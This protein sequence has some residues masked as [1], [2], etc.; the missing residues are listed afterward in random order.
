MN[1]TKPDLKQIKS[2]I[3]KTGSQPRQRVEYQVPVKVEPVDTSTLRPQQIVPHKLNTLVTWLVF[4]LTL[5]VYM[6]TQARS[7][8]FWD[9]GEYATCISILG[10]PH[11]PGNPFYILFGRALVTLFGG[12][13]SHAWLAAFISA[14]TSAF[15]VMFTYLLTVQLASMF[16]IK[17]WEAIFAG[18]MAATLTA[19]SFTFW[20]NAVEAEVYSGLVFFVNMIIWL[21]LYWVQ[22]ARDF[23]NQNILLLILYLFF[24][25]F[26]VHQ[27]A[28]QIAP[29]ILFIA[30]YPLLIQGGK[31]ETFWYKFFGYGAALIMAYLLFG[32]IGKSFRVDALDQIGLALMIV[33]IMIVELHKII[34]PRVWFIGTALVVI[35][36]SAHVMLP[37]RAADRPFINLA[38]PSTPKM[39]DDYI[40]RRQYKPVEQTSMFQRKGN[41]ITHQLGYHFLRYFS[42]Q[43]FKTDAVKRIINMPEKVI[44]VFGGLIVAFLGLFGAVFHFRKNKHSFFYFLAIFICSSILMIWVM[45]LSNDE[46]RDRDY[47]FVVAYNMWAVW[48]G[49]GALALVSLIA[50][51]AGKIALV[52]CLAFLPAF[53]MGV[54]YF[55]HDR[56]REFVALDYGVNFLN[57][58][59]ENAI[60]FTNGDNDTYPIWYAQALQDKYAKEYMHKARDIYPTKDSKAAIANAMAYKNSCLNGIRKDVTVANLS[61][62][63][64]GWYIKQLRDKE[65]VIFNWTD[66]QINSLDDKEGSFFDLL[67]L[68]NTDFS[69]GDPAGKLKFTIPYKDNYLARSEDKESSAFYPEKGSDFSVVQIIKDNFGKRP[70]YFAVTCES[71][72]GFDDYLRNE[73]MVNRLVPEKDDTGSSID[74][75]RL[76]TNIDKVYQYRSIF[77]PRVFKDDNMTRLT[78]NYGSGY[79]RAAIYFA[80]IKDF[81][82]AEAYA[83]QAKKFIKNEF[84]MTEYFVRYYAGTGQWDK[85]DQFVD[86]HI[87]P[88]EDGDRIYNSYVLNTIA[89]EYPLKFTYYMKKLLLKFPDEIDY[90]ALAYYYGEK[91]KLTDQVEQLLGSIQDKL[92]YTA[93]D[94][95]RYLYG[96]DEENAP[97]KDSTNT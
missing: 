63:N 80:K 30:V 73:G 55:E 94:L 86:L 74:I 54:Q 31:R 93:S 1:K 88:I 83:A 97:P 29:A 3:Q 43:W 92:K 9:S 61:L 18:V 70:I 20:M 57:S 68:D 49:I 56:S 67:A 23:H 78:L 75:N 45:N 58:V 77:D 60:I 47:F 52:A 36:L 85:L 5:V 44:T 95:L 51:K 19:F 53:N 28:L 24:I 79:N 32:L 48:M 6:L 50:N 10:V 34:D 42:W 27:L 15:A 13:V 12:L 21:T 2:Q 76:L 82:K 69:G 72:I 46:V 37:I 65:G 33:V 11:P 22:R 4:A 91:Y 25:G 87:L 64:T 66:D 81:K 62:L 89:Q 35:G 26:C 90:G 71:N 7:L 40:Q 17:A 8:S 96:D 39:F 41:L 84:R 14:L 16:K 38:A 59:E